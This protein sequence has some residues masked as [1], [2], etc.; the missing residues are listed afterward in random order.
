MSS[1]EPTD[2]DRENA[3]IRREIADA[4]NAEYAEAERL[5]LARLGPGYT[6]WMKLVLL[7]SD[8]HRTGPRRRS[9]R[10]LRCTVASG[11]FPN[12]VYLRQMPDGQV[13]VALLTKPYS[14]VA[15][16][17]PDER[18]LAVG[19]ERFRLRMVIVSCRAG[20]L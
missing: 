10:P 14:R 18:M 1:S 15:R 4:Q 11:G 16:G 8:Y 7:D 20:A 12:S 6:P 9:P 19:G 17:S 3:A 5:A 2:Q 13:L